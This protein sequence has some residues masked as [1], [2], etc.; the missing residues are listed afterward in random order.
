MPWSLWA[1]L[2]RPRCPRN[3]AFGDRVSCAERIAR[4]FHITGRIHRPVGRAPVTRVGG[5]M[6]GRRGN[7]RCRSGAM[8]S[9]SAVVR[10][11][12]LVA[13]SGP[14]DAVR[15]VE[16]AVA[17]GVGLV[18]VTD[19]G[20]PVGHRQLAGDQLEARSARSSKRSR[21]GVTHRREPIVDGEQVELCQPT[22]QRVGPSSADG[23]LV[24]Q[25]R[26]ADVGR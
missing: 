8:S 14:D 5:A 23:H 24:Q 12:V 7:E 19:D 1:P 16:Q 10:R 21:A 3:P 2:R 20:V 13:S 4:V 22:P 6:V 9:P 11:V 25:A 17:D 15:V 18:G 26:H